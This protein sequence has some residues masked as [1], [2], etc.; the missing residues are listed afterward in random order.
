M[1]DTPD[2]TTAAPIQQTVLNGVHR[3]MGARMVAFGGW[4]MPVQYSGILQEHRAVRETAGLFDISHMGQLWLRG[5]RALAA[6]NSLL[7][8]DV[9]LLEPGRAQYTFMLNEAGGVIDDLIV[10]RLGENEF[11]LI[12]NAA[13]IS[14]D[15]VW[16]RAFLERGFPEV[17][18]VHEPVR[19]GL[20]LQG[21][22]ASQVFAQT[23]AGHVMPQRNMAYELELPQGKL[24]AVGTGYTG[25]AGCEI[26]GPAEVAEWLWNTL[27][28]HGK[29]LGLLPCGLGA[30]DTLRLEMG[31]PLNGNDLAPDRTPLEAGLGMFVA[32]GK[33]A[34]F[35]GKNVLVRQKDEGI[36]QRLTGLVLEGRTPPP[37]AHYPVQHGGEVVG[38]L[39]SG[40]LSPSLGQG[41]GMA[42]LP[43]ALSKPGTALDVVMHGKPYPAK[44]ARRPF[45]K[46]QT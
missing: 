35:P 41:I 39:C 26:F 38:E 23:F 1:A 25:E 11:F 16:M 8:N 33:A 37:R 32:L 4:D 18:L 14:E 34:D 10:Y 20:A 42:Y 17:E 5:E 27:L 22:F 15:L 30:R 40:S 3:E 45:Y 43:V 2:S 19:V 12:I 31:Y 7:T 29:P 21:H 44:V 6:L 24:L 46:V 36:E 9:A 28:E 13:K